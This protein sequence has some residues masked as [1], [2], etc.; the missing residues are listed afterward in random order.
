MPSH[1]Q[2]EHDPPL[3]N[4]S[5]SNNSSNNK[6]KH[7]A[8]V[9]NKVV[10]V[11]NK[12]AKSGSSSSSSSGSTANFIVNETSKLTKKSQ[13]QSVELN[14]LKP[15]S[16]SRSNRNDVKVKAEPIKDSKSQVK[17]EPIKVQQPRV[18]PSAPP[19]PLINQ[20]VLAP[21]AAAAAAAQITSPK[22]N[23]LATKQ[24]HL[25]NDDILRQPL[26]PKLNPKL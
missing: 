23:L 15:K 17:V 5:S 4:Q 10:V 18:Q 26:S 22:K 2:T 16:G 12:N 8:K 19:M 24:F 7:N 9:N 14:K 25:T 21:A 20:T 13:S 6:N 1:T 3:N 11:L